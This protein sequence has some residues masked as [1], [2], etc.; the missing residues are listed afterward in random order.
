MS[1]LTRRRDST[2]ASTR[3]QADAPAAASPN[4]RRAWARASASVRP[5]AT[6]SAVRMSRWNW[7]SSRMS[8]RTSVVVRQGNRNT[9]FV[10]W[11]TMPRLSYV[12]SSTL[13]TA[14]AYRFH[15]DTSARSCER[16]SGVSV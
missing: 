10:S 8:A 6:S 1:V 14:L 11:G 2:R 3:S 13:N 9:R 12:V 5:S 15:A 7:N 16:P 4:S